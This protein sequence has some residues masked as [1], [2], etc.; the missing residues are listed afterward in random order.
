MLKISPKT[1]TVQDIVDAAEKNGY[2]WKR[3]GWFDFKAASLTDYVRDYQIVEGEDINAAC[4]F[5]QAAIN[6]G[7]PF[8]YIRDGLSD[9]ATDYGMSVYSLITRI[10]DRQLMA[11]YPKPN[12]EPPQ[13][14]TYEELVD[15]LKDVTKDVRDKE[16]R[17]A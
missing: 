2:T 15:I 1:V 5:G 11:W 8:N 9:I 3:S 12:E 14:E 4:I 6:L 17:V 10:N 13:A 7:V 16:I